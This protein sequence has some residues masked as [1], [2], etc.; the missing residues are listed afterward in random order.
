MN[1]NNYLIELSESENTDFGRVDFTE[2]SEPQRVF[3][4]IWELESHVN[5]GGF[6][7]YFRYVEPASIVFASIAL[8]TIGATAC[9]AVVEQAIAHVFGS[10]P[11]AAQDDNEQRLDALS[12][13]A[14]EQLY[15]IDKSFIRYPDNLT[16]LLFAFVASHPDTFGPIPM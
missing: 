13:E 2:Q 1:K 6:D 7:S 15:A 12:P 4:A 8:R 9:S 14:Q 11:P 3:S 10:Q 5:S 16:E